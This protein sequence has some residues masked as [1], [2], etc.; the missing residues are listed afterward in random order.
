MCRES[1]QKIINE[2][3]DVMRCLNDVISGKN[4][5]A[6]VIV[7]CQLHVNLKAKTLY[8]I[9]KDCNILYKTFCRYSVR[10]C[11]RHYQLLWVML[12]RKQQDLLKCLTNSL[13]A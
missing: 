2:T 1:L 3:M 9:P 13:T 5:I 4:S 11:P 6:F 12:H 7:F 8:R 10:G